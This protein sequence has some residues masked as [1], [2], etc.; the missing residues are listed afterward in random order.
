MAGIA[1]IFGLLGTVVS[2]MGTIAAGN[3]Q[4]ATAEFEAKQLERRAAEERAAAQREQIDT[5]KQATLVGSRAQA[6]QATSGFGLGSDDPT[7][8]EGLGDI[9]ARGKYQSSMTRYGGDVRAD[10][11]N[12][13]AATKRYEGTL[14][15]K[16][17]QIGAFSTIIG[18]IGSFAGKYGGT[19]NPA[20]TSTYNYFG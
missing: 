20:P 19:F 16:S 2:A 5:E 8:L 17:A 11:A 9:A 18:G 3:A 14:A 6:A 10:Q 7:A 15:Q 13:A 1:P 12:L 4:K